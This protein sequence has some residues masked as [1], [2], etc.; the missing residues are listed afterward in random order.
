MPDKD[1]SLVL[2]KVFGLQEFRAGQEKVIHSILGNQDTLAIMPTGGGKSLC[3]QLPAM[4]FEG[5]TLVVSPLISLM[6]DQV[7]SLQRRGIPA[8]FINSTLSPTEQ[9]Q[10]IQQMNLGHYKLVYVAPERF[11]H[12][13]FLNTLS[14]LKVS[15]FAVDEAHCVSQWGH[16]FR[17]DYLQLKKTIEYLGRPII[18]AFTATATPE[19]QQDITNYLGIQNSQVFVSGFSRTNLELRVIHAAKVVQKFGRLQYLIETHKTGIVYCST[20]KQV[21]QVAERLMEWGVSYVQYHAGLT[22][23]ERKK[24]QEQ[25]MNKRVD[26]AVATNAFGMGIDRSDLRFVAH[27]QMPGTLEAYYQEAGRAGR[28]GHPSVCELLFNYRDRQI[29]EFFLQGSNPSPALIRKLYGTLCDLADSNAE[30]R[31][32]I[33]EM[34]ER[35]DKGTNSIAISAA[36]SFLS[37]SHY[38]DRF[39]IP[40]QRV[41]G[42]RI[43]N[44]NLLPRDLKIDE[45]GL[46]EKETRDRQKLDAVIRYAY[47]AGC[48]QLGILHYFGEKSSAQCG[49]CDVCTHTH[50]ETDNEESSKNVKAKKAGAALSKKGETFTRAPRL[51]TDEE[52]V[53]VQKLLSG[54]ARMS[55]RGHQNEW[56]GRYGRGRI[57]EML[58]ESRNAAILEARLDQLSTYGL[59]KNL[60]K[61]YL[62]TLFEELEMAGLL[63]KQNR[64]GYDLITLT[65]TGALAMRGQVTYKLR[66]PESKKVSFLVSFSSKS[67]LASGRASYGEEDGE[68]E[69]SRETFERKSKKDNK[70]KDESQNIAEEDLGLLEFLKKKRKNIADT[71]R[72]PLY[73]VLNNK[74]LEALATIKPRSLAEVQDLPGVGPVK[75]RT[76][77]PLFLEAIE[78]YLLTEE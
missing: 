8:T 54:V 56:V 28:D 12:S 41:R 37:H 39:D 53:I 46:R 71:R 19:V 23:A 32:S 9:S 51:P 26:V 18:G 57:I 55:F 11:R 49:R 65:D 74:G 48:R 62:K 35:M 69:L 67:K 66:F 1:P 16:D 75:L 31:L 29:Q 14:R 42:T 3:Y 30:V 36:L 64:D 13:Y 4:M 17:P 44:R 73:L 38:V 5:I 70:S 68:S 47:S 6:Q 2:K 63:C 40:G 45:E 77:I 21:E 58:T 7:D 20:R 25:F 59:L 43:L 78:E 60:S 22:D 61:D 27:F 52:L 72:V 76:I 34:T 10:R 33:E 15:F 50:E 24:A